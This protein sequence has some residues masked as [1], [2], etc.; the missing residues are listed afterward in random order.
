LVLLLAQDVVTT[1]DVLHGSTDSC[2]GA[3]IDQLGGF[4][5]LRNI[6]DRIS[7]MPDSRWW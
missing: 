2:V 4:I 3:R 6:G 1:L 7:R 5:R